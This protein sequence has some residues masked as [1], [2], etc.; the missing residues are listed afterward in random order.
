[1]ARS[2][3]LFT[4]VVT[5]W[6][7]FA[8]LTR[9]APLGANATS[10][11]TCDCYKA[12]ATSTNFFDHRKFFD[13]RD[14]AGA[15]VPA[16]IDGRDQDAGAPLTNAYFSTAEW[17]DT[18]GIQTWP[19]SGGPVY[20]V[21]S[22]NNVYI[23]ADTDASPASRTHLTMRTLRQSDYQSTAEFES[24]SPQYQ[25]LS[26]RMLARTQGDGGAVTSMS[27]Y[28]GG[29][30]VQEADLEIRTDTATNIAQ[31]TNQP[32]TVDGEVVPDATHVTTLATPWTD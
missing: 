30:P 27:T 3:S 26:V 21:N 11:A 5:S 15:A 19:T 9:C 12:E 23:E 1:M 8:G 28:L 25:Y 4:T 13:F 6:A 14:M 16:P 18:W 32:G 17:T 29:A 24:K 22:P 7:V 2:Q 31:Y 20:R 10:D